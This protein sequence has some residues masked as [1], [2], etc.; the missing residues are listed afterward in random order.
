M[1]GSNTRMIEKGIGSDAD[2]IFLDLE[3]AVAISEKETARATVASSIASLDWGRK[4]RAFRVNALD[5]PFFYRDLID[6]VEA[7]GAAVELIVVPKV[8]R[9]EDVYVLDTLL[10]QLE[11]RVEHPGRIGLEI[12]IET[13][14]GLVNC[15]RIAAASSRIEAL[16]FGPGDFAASAGMPAEQIGMPDSWD[17]RYPG[18]RWHYAMSRI[19][20]AAKAAG[21]RAIDGPYADFRNL[22]GLRGSCE[23]A[24]GLGFD[25][26]WCIH[27]AQIET[28]NEVFSPAADEIAWA[29][30]VIAEYRRAGERGAGAMAID[31]KMIDGASIR[32]AERTLSSVIAG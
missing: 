14:G 11:V 19:V 23:I 28:V 2:L 26:K 18:H 1:P 3:D 32:M 9:P 25:G 30:R 15:E 31:G 12:Q 4:P 16:T 13:A 5:T 22:E 7:A 10:N 27:P 17:A 6:V 8:N 29:R 24:R 21:V 20:V